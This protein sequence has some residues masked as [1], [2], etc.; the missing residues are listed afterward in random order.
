MLEDQVT[1]F[2]ETAITKTKSNRLSWSRPAIA[3]LNK[4]PYSGWDK[5][6]C[7]IA[8]YKQ[9]TIALAKDSEEDDVYC[10]IRPEPTMSY[11]EIGAPDDP[12]LRRLYNI[13]YSKFPSVESFIESF[14]SD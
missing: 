10:F 6:R 13:V 1:S 2:F 8:K 14:I 11:Q 5:D 3:D 12:L 4:L 7:F 9:G